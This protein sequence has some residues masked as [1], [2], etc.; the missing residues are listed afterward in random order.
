ML[1]SMMMLGGAMAVA[2]AAPTAGARESFTLEIG[3]KQLTAPVP[4]GYC[5]P[6]GKDKEA[7]EMFARGDTQNFTPVTL[8]RC[9]RQ[10]HPQGFGPDY[11]LIKTPRE[12]VGA[13]IER[14]EFLKLM[15]A[16][17]G[18]AEWQSGERTDALL[19]NASKE[20]SSAVGTNVAISGALRPRGVDKSCA[21]LGGT[22]N[23]ATENQTLPVLAGACLTSVA[24]KLLSVNAY[25]EAKPPADAAGQMRRA[26]DLAMQ[27]KPAP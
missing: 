12:T 9:D 1:K 3:G 8:I 13:V 4:E 17:M 18:K 7:A 5:I 2:A 25:G 21:Y 26:R 14:A 15:E 16:E 22:L 6:K 23:V 19:E 27:L 11:F 10:N 20:V 24:G